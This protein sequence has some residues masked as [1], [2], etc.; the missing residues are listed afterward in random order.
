M[1]KFARFLAMAVAL[2][3]APFG[4]TATN[5]TGTFKH[6]DGSLVNGKLILRLSQA[7]KLSDNSAQIV[8]LVKIFD[9]TNGALESGAFVYGN[10]V[11]L[12]TGTYYVARLVDSNNNLLFEQKWSITGTNLDLGELTPTST[13]VTLVD[14][15]VRNVTTSQVVQGPVTFS[16]PLT[17]LSLTLN[18]NL[19]PGTTGAY[20]LG[21]PTLAWREFYAQRWNGNFAP[22]SGTGLVTAPATAPQVGVV[23]TGGSLDNTPR[24]LRITLITLLGETPPS[25]VATITPSTCSGGACRI[26]VNVAGNEW[27][28]GAFGYRVY[29]CAD[30]S[31]TTTCYRQTGFLEELDTTGALANAHYSPGTVYLASITL[32]GTQPPTTNTATID[33]DQVALNAACNDLAAGYARCYGTLQYKPNPVLGYAQT[34]TTPLV[35]AW[36]NARIQGH[37][38]SGLDDINSGSTRNCT[39]SHIKLGCVMLMNVNGVRIDG[40]NVNANNLNGYLLNTWTN[41]FNQIEIGNAVV[42]VTGTTPVAPLRIK[43]LWYYIKFPNL[44]L[45]ASLSGTGANKGAGVLISNAA[46]ANWHFGGPPVRWTIDDRADAWRNDLGHTDPDKGETTAFPNMIGEFKADNVQIQWSPTGLGQGVL[47]KGGN[48]VLMLDGVTH[49]DYNPAAG[50]GPLIEFGADTLAAGACCTDAFIRNAPYLVP[51]AN[52]SAGIKL[53]ANASNA[54]ASLTLDNVFIPHTN[55]VDLNSTGLNSLVIR[56]PRSL[57]VCNP[58]ATTNK[59]I[60]A[61]ANQTI[62]CAY[63]A[64]GTVASRIANQS[65]TGGVG[66]FDTNDR[67][68]SM[69]MYW[70]GVGRL[71]W[72]KG[73]DPTATAN[74]FVEMWVNSTNKRWFA[75]DSAGTGTLFDIN[76]NAGM[77]AIGIGRNADAS[78]LISVPNNTR[79][80]ARNNANSTWIPLIASNT[81]DQVVVGFSGSPVVPGSAGLNLGAT[82]TRWGTFFTSSQVDSSLATGTAP[83][84]IASTTLVS[85]LNVQKWNGKDAIDFSGALDFGSIAAQTC[86]TLTITATGAAADNPVAPSWPAALEAGLTGLMHVTASNT[87]TVRLC[88]VTASA[89]DPASQ[90]FAGRVVK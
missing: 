22:A 39:F 62:H 57:E 15:L 42:A 28:Q 79:M 67:A 37:G 74:Q 63:A 90:T 64:G 19:N 25:P 2:L 6:H 29:A 55:M 69:Q 9:V 41:T 51:T 35:V 45:R 59:I 81:N 17:A 5:L 80:A 60:N 77:N 88:N 75:F 73:P 70:A 84:V 48:A 16:S 13:G 86:A 52:N 78:N 11:L 46:G 44:Q 7:A 54:F 85:N 26:Y 10:D 4:L 68:N 82:G 53:I 24:Y 43:G 38:T 61:V 23:T 47:F 14:P 31:S 58:N 3:I 18:G 12:P 66:F 34:G 8:P 40:L 65:F 21:S 33:A 49:S 76:A 30:T 1:S 87:V 27:R 50:T 72:N 89:I 71:Q 20:D 83:L 32:S 36:H 56:S